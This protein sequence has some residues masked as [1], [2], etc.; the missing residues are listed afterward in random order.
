MSR[1]FVVLYLCFL[2]ALTGC[3]GPSIAIPPTPTPDPTM[4]RPVHNHA[5]GE[6]SPGGDNTRLITRYGGAVSVGLEVEPATP[7]PGAPFTATYTLNDKAGSPITPDRL[8]ETHERLMHLIVVSQ[9]LRHFSHVHP[10]HAGD[11]RYRVSDLLPSAGKYLLFDEFV[12]SDGATQIE[13][14]LVSTADAPDHPAALTPDLGTPQEAEGLTVVMT[15]TAKVRRRGPSTFT[16]LVNRD[17][18]PVT[19]LEPYLGAPCHV[20]LV[21]ADTRQFAH[22]HGDLPGAAA[23][24]GAN[25]M[26]GMAMPPPPAQFGPRLEFTHTFMQAGLYR[27][28][29]QFG[30]Q[31][32]VVTVGY[33]VQVSK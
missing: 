26:A 33:N 29:A 8:L 18:K 9:D 23:S 10:E 14:H 28:W 15:A 2:I 7:R 5:H 3:S 4:A 21:S 19:D 24:T 31:G 13:R 16:L 32:K 1:V 6:V 11:G 17:G 20:V 30:Y 12:T 27:M 22:T 25:G